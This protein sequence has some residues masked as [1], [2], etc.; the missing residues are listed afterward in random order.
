MNTPWWPGP[1]RS[2]LWILARA[3]W[4]DEAEV[5]GLTDRAAKLGF[6]VEELIFVEHTIQNTTKTAKGQ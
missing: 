3:P 6:A 4:L 5:R 1:T 2:Y